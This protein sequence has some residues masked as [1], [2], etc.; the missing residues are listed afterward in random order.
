[1]EDAVRPKVLPRFKIRR[2]PKVRV[3]TSASKRAGMSP[4]YLAAIRRLPSCV[5]GQTPCEAHH[6]KCAGGRG[7]SLKAEDKW[8]VPLT[9]DEHIN[10]VERVGSKR[11]FDWFRVRGINCLDL[12][13]ALWAA[14]PD[15]AKM[16][17]VLNAH[18]G[19]RHE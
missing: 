9:R 14:F 8:A 16:L 19:S 7:V 1:M 17:R 5:S 12:A 3:A 13:A 2:L 4:A 6:L 10:G 11:E 15:E 18:R